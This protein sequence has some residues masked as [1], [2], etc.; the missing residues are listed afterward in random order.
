[1]APWSCCFAPGAL[2][3]NSRFFPAGFSKIISG[4]PKANKI[5]LARNSLNG[6]LREAWKGK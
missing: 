3:T 4:L 2:A 5:R 6:E 1:M